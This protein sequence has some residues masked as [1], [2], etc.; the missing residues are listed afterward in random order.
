MQA[1]LQ[2]VSQSYANEIT[3]PEYGE[4][5]NGLLSAR[6]G[7]LTGIVNGISYKDWNPETD[8]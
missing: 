2:P 1:R 3:T 4:G 6:R 5:L 7:D 8:R